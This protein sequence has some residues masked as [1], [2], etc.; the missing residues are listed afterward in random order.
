MPAITGIPAP[1]GSVG[2][3]AQ[4]LADEKIEH[5]GQILPIEDVERVVDM[6]DSI[7]RLPCGCRFLTTGRT[8]QRYCFGVGIDRWGVLGRF[9]EASASLEVLPKEEAKRI[10]RDYDREGLVHSI[11]TGVT[12]FVVG[13]C[14]CDR[15]CGAYKGYIE[16]GSSPTF[17]R[18]EY[19]AQVDWDLCTGCKSCISQCQFG[20]EF[21]SSSLSKVYVHPGKCFGC[22]VCRTA[23]EQGAISLVPRE[24]VPDAAGVW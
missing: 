15:D 18:A 13:I 19:V 22:G 14:N 2:F 12:P 8:D 3:S 21:Y 4:S 9:P 17:F 20:A 5:Y 10:F 1:P 16:Q 7:T 6:V 23:C 24:Q 11:W